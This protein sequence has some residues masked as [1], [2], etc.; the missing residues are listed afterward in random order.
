[1]V[2]LLSFYFR[3]IGDVIV[4]GLGLTLLMVCMIAN[5]FW[6]GFPQTQLAAMLPI[7][8]LALG[9]DFVIHSLTRWR[10]LTLDNP[11]YSTDPHTASF[12]GAWQSIQ[13]LFPALGVATLT[14]VVAFGTATLSKIPDEYYFQPIS[15]R[16]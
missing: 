7:L 6:L 1:M 13:S 14:T 10:R 9:V 12:E 4:S 5:S 3:N 11:N 8:M 16:Y 2:L 15:F